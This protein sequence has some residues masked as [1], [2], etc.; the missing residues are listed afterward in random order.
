MKFASRFSFSVVLVVVLVSFLTAQQR[1]ASSAAA[2]TS[3]VSQSNAPDSCGHVFTAGSGDNSILYCVT[4][5]GNIT[6]IETP[7]TH[8]MIGAGGEGYGLCQESPA[9]EY[10][11]YAANWSNNW[12][13]PQIVTLTK[14]VIK[15]SRTTS[16]GNWTLVQTISKIAATASIKVVMALTNNQSVDKVAY[17][18]RFADIDPNYANHSV[19]AGGASLES[20]WSWDATDYSFHYGLQLLNSSK[21]PFS[22]RQGF[23][24][25]SN[26]GPNACDFAAGS[27]SAGFAG[28]NQINVS[29]SYTYAGVVPAHQTLTV[30]MNY[31]RT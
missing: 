11:D 16:D 8:P 29:V 21:S 12:N 5:T 4:D 7:I 2:T 30:T 27:A 31:R 15:I 26:P 14:S 17:L 9:A 3:A 13:Y 20:A 18:L 28:D 1:T 19:T 22:Y 6:T 24:Y 23:V 25:F 10:H